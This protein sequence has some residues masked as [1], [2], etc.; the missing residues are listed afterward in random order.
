MIIQRR[1]RRIPD[2]DAQIKG[3]LDRTF[4]EGRGCIMELDVVDEPLETSQHWIEVS[5]SYVRSL[6]RSALN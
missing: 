5:R 1:L 2:A 3:I 6:G 4:D